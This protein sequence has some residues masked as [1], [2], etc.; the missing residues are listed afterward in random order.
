MILKTRGKKYEI[1][2]EE[3]FIDFLEKNG[4]N[5]KRKEAIE[6][7]S[8]NKINAIQLSK[9]PF[10]KQKKSKENKKQV[11]IKKQDEQKSKVD[12]FG[13]ECPEKTKLYF[14]R[15][16]QIIKSFENPPQRFLEK[17][18]YYV[19]LK[20]YDYYALVIQNNFNYFRDFNYEILDKKD[21]FYFDL[22]YIKMSILKKYFDYRKILNINSNCFF[23]GFNKKVIEKIPSKPLMII[24][25]LEK[26]KE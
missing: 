25:F 9:L 1:F 2:D 7:F 5:Y 14:E 21:G 12:T 19:Y 11:K 17:T 22:F 6:F 23:E 10:K 18:L 3:E 20:D 15:L 8:K 4:Y 26:L 24:D 13:Q 16:K